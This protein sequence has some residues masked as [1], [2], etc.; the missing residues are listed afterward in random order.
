MGSLQ[1][2]E[3][4][5][6]RLQAEIDA[7]WPLDTPCPLEVWIRNKDMAMT[8]MCKYCEPKDGKHE[9]ECPFVT[10]RQTMPNKYASRD[11]D[12][13][14]EDL[15][16]ID[17]DHYTKRTPEPIDVIDGWHLGFN[18]GNAVKY[19]ARAALSGAHKKDMLKAA[20]YCY[21]AATGKWLPKELQD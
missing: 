18:M 11:D 9:P 10:G 15:Q 20:N 8:M 5:K 12:L 3:Y 4:L 7:V 2:V 13:K 19:I 1:D 14:K 17:P 21:R 6:S 16:A